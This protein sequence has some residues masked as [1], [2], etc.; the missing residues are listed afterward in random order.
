MNNDFKSVTFFS[1]GEIG[2]KSIRDYQQAAWQMLK[3]LRYK[4]NNK[5]Y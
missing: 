3:P 4:L 2:S 1:S 5:S